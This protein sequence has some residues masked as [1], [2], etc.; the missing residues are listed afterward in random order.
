MVETS[1]IN[2]S[3]SDPTGRRRLHE[4]IERLREH[5]PPHITH[6]Q[7]EAQIADKVTA[8][9]HVD[10]ST[11]QRVL[12]RHPEVAAQQTFTPDQVKKIVLELPVSREPNVVYISKVAAL[13]T[14]E[15]LSK[16]RRVA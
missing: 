1:L 10:A 4:G 13:I 15:F 12:N 5:R 16:L 7:K 9:A 3:L 8:I 11:A 2:F 6:A 14:K